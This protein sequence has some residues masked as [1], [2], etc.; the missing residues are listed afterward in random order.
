[1]RDEQFVVQLVDKI[2]KQAIARGASDIH[3]EPEQQRLRIRFRVDGVLLDQMPI[4]VSDMAQMLSRLKVLAHINIAEKRIP[5]D[6]K[7]SLRVNN[8][9]IDLRVSTFPSLYG[10]KIVIRIL[11]RAAHM[12]TLQNLGFSAGMLKKF[13]DL[14]H[15]SNGF[16]LVTGPTGSGKTTTLYAALAALNAPEKNI[17]TLEDPVEYNLTGI[18][19]GHINPDAGFTFEKGIRAVLRQDPD[20]LMVGEVRDKQTARI[21]IEAALTGHVV[22][23]TLHTNDAPSAVMRLMDMQI[24]P[25]LINASLTGVLAQRLAR[26]ICTA[27]RQEVQPSEQERALLGEFDLDWDVVYKGAGCSAC[28]NLGYKGRIGIFE[29]LTVTSSLRALIVQQPVFEDIYAQALAD[30][31]ITLLDDGLEKVHAGIITLEELMRVV[32]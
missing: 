12:I 20:V 19:Q 30:G 22:L 14:M 3:L 4:D 8:Q 25:F 26:K 21:A 18:T 13:N 9:P 27:C 7:F 31:M 32:I 1:M 6:G 23:S 17:V 5:Q 15:R 2:L 29:L 10:E 28:G 11:D 16:F 24:E